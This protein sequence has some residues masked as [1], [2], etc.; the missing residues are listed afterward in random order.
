MAV[1]LL[2]RR[3]RTR[4]AASTQLP[5]TSPTNI[6]Q[7]FSLLLT[8][9]RQYYRLPYLPT[10]QT[11][12]RY[13]LHIFLHFP[14]CFVSGSSSIRNDFALL[15]TVDPDPEQGAWKFTKIT[16]KPDF[17]PLKMAFVPTQVPYFYNLLVLSPEYIFHFKIHLFVTAKSDQKSDLAPWIWIRICI[18]IEVKKLDPGPK[19]FFPIYTTYINRIPILS[20]ADLLKYGKPLIS[21]LLFALFS[22]KF[23]LFFYFPVSTPSVPDPFQGIQQPPAT[24]SGI[25]PTNLDC[26]TF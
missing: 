17:K 1:Y 18:R 20:S 23:F 5:A 22:D 14:T 10:C 12:Y 24:G 6:C 3:V 2:L 7:S 25:Y 26:I 13:F 15:G 4:G 9:P 21:H 8:S 11:V 16:N 19:H